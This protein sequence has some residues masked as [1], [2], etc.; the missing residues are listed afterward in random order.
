MS[1]VWWE[2]LAILSGSTIL[3][4]WI[5]PF[6][7]QYAIQKNILDHPIEHKSHTVAVPYLGGVAIVI[8]FVVVV[9][10]LSLIQFSNE[11]Q[12]ELLIVLLIAVGLSFVGLIDD[13]RKLSPVWRIATEIVAAIIVWSL[14]VGIT[15]T[16]VG[17]VDCILTILWIVGIT[18]AFNL[19]DNMDGLSAGIAAISGLTIFALAATNRQFLVAGL[20]IGFVGCVGGFLRHNF[21]PARIYMGDGGALFVGF[22]ISYLGMKLRFDH[23]RVISA[24]VPVSACSLAVFDTTIVT[25]S[26]LANK[27]SPFQGGQDHVSHRLVRIGLPVPLAVSTIYAGAIGIGILTYVIANSDLAS[28]WVLI[29]LIGATLVVSGWYLLKVPVYPENS[30]DE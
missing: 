20:S 12:T 8:V 4:V 21:H 18:N 9:I 1:G 10:S 11:D 13:L 28:A 5:T 19:L 16:T 3:C 22:M 6:V 15:V 14:G 26:R 17:I 23:D 24:L 2:Y 29:G 7:I 30:E 25:V 27:R